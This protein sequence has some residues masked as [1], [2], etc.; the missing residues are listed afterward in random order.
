MS[1]LGPEAMKLL[2]TVAIVAFF[3][4]ASAL[5]YRPP[6]PKPADAPLTEFSAG[7][8]REVLRGLVGDGQ[9]HPTGSL[10]AGR[11]RQRIVAQLEQLGYAPEIQEKF[12]CGVVRLC[13]RVTNVLARLDGTG[14]GKAVLLSV[15]YDSVPA[16]PGASDDGIGVAAALEVARA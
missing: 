10:A 5:R 1:R 3:V 4:A 12:A 16:G 15:H 13:A 8:A 14:R 11:V 2:A 6:S 7:R 9:P